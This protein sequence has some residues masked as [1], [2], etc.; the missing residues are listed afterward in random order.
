MAGI[1][2]FIA[3]HV[4][5]TCRAA[6]TTQFN[7]SEESQ[8]LGI[9]NVSPFNRSSTTSKTDFAEI[10][11]SADT[12]PHLQETQDQA[13]IFER[14]VEDCVLRTL[15]IS[16][17][18]N[19]EE[20]NTTSLHQ[21]SLS[22]NGV[23]NRKS[24]NDLSLLEI[25]N[26]HYELQQQE[27]QQQEDAQNQSIN[28]PEMLQVELQTSDGICEPSVIEISSE[29]QLNPTEDST[30]HQSTPEVSSLESIICDMP[31]IDIQTETT[32]IENTVTLETQESMSTSYQTIP[33]NHDT[34]NFSQKTNEV[35]NNEM[36]TLEVSSSNQMNNTLESFTV[37]FEGGNS[38]P[39]C[40]CP[41]WQQH[42][43]PCLHMFA[44]FQSCPGWNYDMLSPIY[45]MNNVFHFDYSCLALV[46][47]RS[48]SV[49]CEKGIQ[50][51]EGA[52][53]VRIAA[54]QTQ[55]NTCN[56]RIFKQMNNFHITEAFSQQVSDLLFQLNKSSFLFRDIILYK[57]LKGQL[58]DIVKACRAR[59]I[60]QQNEEMLQKVSLQNF[61][62]FETIL[63]PNQ[64]SANCFDQAMTGTPLD[65]NLANTVNAEDFDK[66]LAAVSQY[67]T[68]GNEQVVPPGTL[69][70]PSSLTKPATI[71]K[72][73]KKVIVRVKPSSMVSTVAAAK[74]TNLVA[75][76]ASSPSPV[77]EP[78]T[79]T[80][81]VNLPVLQSGIKR[82]AA[83]ILSEIEAAKNKLF[84]KT[85]ILEYLPL[86]KRKC[87]TP[88][89]L[90]KNSLK[91]LSKQLIPTSLTSTTATEP[92]V[93]I[94]ANRNESQMDFVVHTQAMEPSTITSPIST[95]VSD[96]TFS[97]SNN[98][99]SD[100]TN[101][102]EVIQQPQQQTQVE[103]QQSSFN[104]NIS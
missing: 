44:I 65:P 76:Q 73:S 86:L 32:V 62:K 17:T 89:E 18:Q 103:V 9:F 88:E 23:I 10:V 70:K 93:N 42:K 98:L 4:Y 63:L 66:L 41:Y 57:H 25:D 82:D 61:P 12:V 35:D 1:P 38:Y 92:Q 77:T 96:N 40:T 27:H 15:G 52:P 3:Q 36:N 53:T 71:R 48:S 51:S 26:T 29:I 24:S 49:R 85:S 102:K 39:F 55:K 16:E 74:K 34:L 13:V 46:S 54:V 72:D 91:L 75:T 11:V 30:N 14:A 68:T 104:V 69:T 5:S 6:S 58:T 37:S 7:I 47:G 83:H 84:N 78:V 90:E 50:T 33:T 8:I 101:L 19:G 56:E 21:E 79:T 45:R 28:N 87:V 64:L 94:V 59:I 95:T 43:L 20:Q 80:T 99:S 22:T 81:S 67:V 31:D 97:E 2:P 100:S 60:K